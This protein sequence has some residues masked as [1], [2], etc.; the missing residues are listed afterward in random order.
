[1]QLEVTWYKIR[2]TGTQKNVS[3]SKI[4]Q[5]KLEK[6]DFSFFIFPSGVLSHS[7]ALQYVGFCSM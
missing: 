2:H 1:M 6:C 4:E 7:F 3:D 5:L